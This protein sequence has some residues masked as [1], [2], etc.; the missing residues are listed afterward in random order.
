MSAKKRF[1][2]PDEVRLTRKARERR[3]ARWELAKAGLSVA[4]KF[5]L[6]A[7]GI[8]AGVYFASLRFL[9]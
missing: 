2:W 5:L 4:L 6:L 1:V 8:A 9:P 7:A 3:E